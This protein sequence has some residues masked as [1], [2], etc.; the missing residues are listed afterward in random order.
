MSNVPAKVIGQ[1]TGDQSKYNTYGYRIFVAGFLFALVGFLL[2]LGEALFWEQRIFAL[3]EPAFIALMLSLLCILFGIVLLLPIPETGV[4]LAVAGAAASVFGILAFVY[5]Y[6]SNWPRGAITTSSLIVVSVYGLGAGVVAGIAALTPTARA[7]MESDEPTAEQAEHLADESS[8]SSDVRMGERSDRVFF[9]VFDNESW[10]WRFVSEEAMAA[11]PRNQETV[12]ASRRDIDR[13]K[14]LL[15]EASIVDDYAST[16][17]VHQRTGDGWSW[18][19]L[20]EGENIAAQTRTFETAQQASESAEFVTKEAPDA[21]TLTMDGPAFQYYQDDGWYWRLLDASRSEQ[22]RATIGTE[23]KDESIQTVET[24]QSL[25]SDA[26]ILEFEDYAVEVFNDEG[27]WRWRVLSG[28][29]ETFGVGTTSE[30]SSKTAEQVAGETVQQLRDTPVVRTDSERYEVYATS[31]NRWQWKLLDSDSTTIAKNALRLDGADDAE[32]NARWFAKAD[33]AEIIV[34]RGGQAFY[35]IYQEGDG[36]NWQLIDS[37]EGVLAVD[38]AD[39]PD[40]EAVIRD[41]RA[42]EDARQHASTFNFDG[43]VFIIYGSNDETWGWRLLNKH[44]RLQ[45]NNQE[46]FESEGN[47][48]WSIVSLKEHA[49]DAEIFRQSDPT[50]E[51]YETEDGTWRWRLVNH[52]GQVLATSPKEYG[53]KAE[54]KDAI[55]RAANATR[56]DDS[57]HIVSKETFQIYSDGQGWRWRYSIPNGPVIAKSPERFENPEAAEA[58]VNQVKTTKRRASSVTFDSGAIL[59]TPTNSGSSWKFVTSKRES[60]LHSTNDDMSVEAAQRH[61][62]GVQERAAQIPTFQLENLAFWVERDETAWQWSLI[63][64]SYTTIAT[65]SKRYENAEKTVDTVDRI[66]EIAEDADSL[67]FDSAVFEVTESNDRWSWQLLNE[68]WQPQ[69]RAKNAHADRESAERE[70]ERFKS[71]VAWASRYVI[72]PAVIEVYQENTTDAENDGGWRWRLIDS[73]GDVL[74]ENAASLSSHERAMEIAELVKESG[75]EAET[76]VSR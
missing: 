62:E 61:L 55:E 37:E 1:P 52:S 41:V 38:S 30:R 42:F 43:P 75:P 34:I 11:T 27:E 19:Y 60:R 48:T 21:E 44:G 69:A 47:A 76:I 56:K 46:E 57:P 51:V 68:R 63:D 22:A 40:R 16:M 28:R 26:E 24:I 25:I 5:V 12:S 29:A 49:P 20:L 17:Q 14:R 32:E 4:K 58:S 73:S 53:N 71:N 2:F 54:A 36:Y 31:G 3:R 23:E 13:V 45:A 6:P 15:D 8:Q 70:I 33:D 50:Y 7:L 67:T 59:L 39:A 72:D 18:S 64:S 74:A 65:D 66:V 9:S 10:T 35:E